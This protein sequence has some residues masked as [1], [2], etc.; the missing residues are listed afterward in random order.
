VH[1]K[2]LNSPHDSSCVSR[3][4]LTEL[5]VLTGDAM[6]CQAWV[7]LFGELSLGCND[8]KLGLIR[9]AAAFLFMSCSKSVHSGMQSAK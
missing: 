9:D 8:V 6:L 1:G 5:A 7:C 3:P 4:F 2:W